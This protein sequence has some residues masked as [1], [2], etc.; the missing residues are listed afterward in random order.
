M[1]KFGMGF[2]FASFAAFMM[3][4]GSVTSADAAGRYGKQKVVYH[5]NYPGGKDDKKYA[6][7]MRNIQN[8][9]NAV[10]AKNL[11]LKVVIH[12]NGISLLQSAKAPGKIQSAV[13]SLK[14]QN[15]SF[16]VC[17]NTLASKKVKS[18]DLYEVF[19]NDIVPSGVAEL[20]YLQQKGYT[21]IKP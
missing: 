12:G 7:A 11:D 4:I 10:G 1:R 18:D 8:H 19:D 20:A 9:I 3:L 5:I 17:A 2:I 13:A 6:G 21:Y 14:S 15:V 16:A